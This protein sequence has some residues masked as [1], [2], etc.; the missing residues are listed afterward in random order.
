MTDCK[1]LKDKSGKSRRIAYIGFKSNRDAS[2]AL[3]K[4]NGSTIGIAKLTVERCKELKQ[5]LTDPKRNTNKKNK[6]KNFLSDKVDPDL[7]DSDDDDDEK[8]FWWSLLKL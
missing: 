3:K 8:V 5:I 7:V 6:T 1:L 4:L 2:D